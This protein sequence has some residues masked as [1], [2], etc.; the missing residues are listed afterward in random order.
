MA[1]KLAFSTDYNVSYDF[2]QT[3]G[4]K[5]P[6]RWADVNSI[7]FVLR[8]GC[9]VRSRNVCDRV[10]EKALRPRE[11][12]WDNDWDADKCKPRRR[13][14]FKSGD[15]LQHLS[16][17][18]PTKSGREKSRMEMHLQ[19]SGW[20]VQNS[21]TDRCDSPNYIGRCAWKLTE[22]EANIHITR[23]GVQWVFWGTKNGDKILHERI[24]SW[25]SSRIPR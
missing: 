5:K 2:D 19:N 25:P 23:V 17:E 8:K 7:K 18:S 13:C 10:A 1:A 16:Q 24:E 11:R 4:S 15:H 21:S 20:E 3:N 12:K 22:P 6:E 14:N 9:P